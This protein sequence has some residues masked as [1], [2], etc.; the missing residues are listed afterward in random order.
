MTATFFPGAAAL[1]RLLA[2]A[3]AVA[4]ALPLLAVPVQSQPELPR[5]DVTLVR[6]SLFVSDRDRMNLEFRVTNT[7]SESLENLAVHVALYDRVTSRSEL[8]ESFDGV[9]GLEVGVLLKDYPKLSI[10]A[11]DTARVELTE[12]IDSFAALTPGADNGVY[13]MTISL[14]D[15]SEL[16]LDALTTQLIYYGARPETTLNMV[17]LVP[18]VELASRRS[19]GVFRP[20]GE[21]IP[22][23]SALGPQG[24]LAGVTSALGEAVDSGLQV[25][26][27]AGP[28]TVEEIADISDGYRRSVG[29][30]EETVEANSSVSQ[31]AREILGALS[32]LAQEE[33]VQLVSTPFSFADLPAMVTHFTPELLV[34]HLPAQLSHGE[35]VVEN[36]LNFD[37]GHE[38]L[39]SPGE[40][41][42]RPT[43]DA[44]RGLGAAAFTFFSPRSLVSLPV[45]K[46]GCPEASPTFACPISV[47]TAAGTTRGYVADAELQ[48]RLFDLQKNQDASLALQRFFAETALIREELPAIGGRVIHALV[49]ST[50]RPV[51]TL[52]T[53]LFRGLAD[54]PWMSTTTP[55]D[56]LESLTPPVERQVIEATD[57]GTMP[58]P[59]YFSEIAR[60]HEVVESLAEMRPPALTIQRIRR[61]LLVAESRSWFLDPGVV[62]VGASYAT[63]ARLQAQ[64]QIDQVHI[65]GNNVITLTSRNG[66]LQLTIFNET[67][68]PVTLR[69]GLESQDLRVE[70]LPPQE[71]APGT[72]PVEIDVTAESSGIFPVQVSLK[73]AGGVLVA[74]PKTVS[75]RSTELNEI[76]LV[77]T[78][79]AFGFLIL[80]YVVKG[81]RRR[82]TAQETAAG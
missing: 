37:I 38:W 17:L 79:G 27:A 31:N 76:A 64:S 57:L 34:D 49:P 41:V 8:H 51:P 58:D 63:G 16:P 13:P 70:E 7:S 32:E 74:G 39:L 10:P 35:V 65:G 42:D 33:G 1:L 78:L 3:A 73:T 19:D 56:G 9:T 50:W 66:T 46:A 30:E 18:I 60:A 77:I 61:D 5:A 71:F 48:E 14:L 81:L 22:L 69:L 68:Y 45:E 62:S 82:R 29:D 28:R 47:R 72:T 75:V 6:Q 43:L 44:L 12:P 55:R 2:V 25:G 26:V 20:I 24:W 52:A 11:G 80:F 15:D 53:R 4:L 36:Q 59:F 40:R 67:D 21:V 54:A 23:E